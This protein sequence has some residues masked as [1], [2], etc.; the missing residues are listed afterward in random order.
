MWLVLLLAQPVQL[1]LLFLLLLLLPAA[2]CR[3]AHELAHHHTEGW[4]KRSR[5]LGVTLLCITISAFIAY[6]LPFF[7]IVM[8]VI[9]SLGDVM[10]MFGLPCL[11]ALKLL[12][13][14][15]TEAYACGV[16]LVL[17]VGLSGCGIFSSV[18]QLVEAY[19]GQ[20]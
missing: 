4:S 12:K 5:W 9:A 11:F 8:A 17:A 16:L 7:S 18:Q 20:G 3:Y 14:R 13:L 6:T 1:L 15:R 2:P 10:S 19:M